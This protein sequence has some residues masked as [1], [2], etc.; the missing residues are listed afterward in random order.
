MTLTNN[1]VNK[2]DSNGCSPGCCTIAGIVFWG[3]FFGTLAFL[4]YGNEKQNTNTVPKKEPTSIDTCNM[5]K[6]SIR[7]YKV[8]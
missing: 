7:V 4:D 3:L 2:Q 5:V 6:D 8:R 1:R